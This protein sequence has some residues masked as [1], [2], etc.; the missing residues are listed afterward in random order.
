MIS[1]I[2]LT[3]KHNMKYKQFKLL[4]DLL[5]NTVNLQHLKL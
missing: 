4:S 3:R 1:I 5:V 2:L